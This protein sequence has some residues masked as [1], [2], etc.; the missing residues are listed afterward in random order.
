MNRYDIAIKI[1][2]VF[3]FDNKLIS[4]LP[5]EKLIQKAKRPE[6]AGL[7]T[8]KAETDLGISFTTLENG[9]HSLK[10]QMERFNSKFDYIS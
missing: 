4:E 6:K 1:S 10:Y 2:D 9:L 8:L 7:I 5:V 3:G